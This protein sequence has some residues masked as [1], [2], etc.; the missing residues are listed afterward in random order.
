MDDRLEI[1]CLIGKGGMGHV[2]KATH[3]TTGRTV[4]LKVMFPTLLE[5]DETRTRSSAK[6]RYSELSC[7][8]I[9]TFYHFGIWQERTPYIAMEFLEGKTFQETLAT[10][11]LRWCG[12]ES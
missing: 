9:P 4:A 3:L 11:R 8:N 12:G 5:A 6:A 2:Y 10:E 7:S 1:V